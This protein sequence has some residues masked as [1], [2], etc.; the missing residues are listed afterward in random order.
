MAVLV[1]L[2]CMAVEGQMEGGDEVRVVGG[3]GGKVE[4]KRWKIF[5]R[6]TLRWWA[7][8]ICLF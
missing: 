3:D 4:A 7:S 5:G 1:E 6:E 8:H 2:M